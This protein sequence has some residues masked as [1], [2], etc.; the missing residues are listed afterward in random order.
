MSLSVRRSVILHPKC[1][2]GPLGEYCMVHIGRTTHAPLSECGTVALCQ[3]WRVSD[4]K[5]QK[6][7]RAGWNWHMVFQNNWG[8]GCCAFDAPRTRHRLRGNYSHPLDLPSSLPSAQ[9]DAVTAKI[10]V[11]WS[12]LDGKSVQI[13]LKIATGVSTPAPRLGSEGLGPT[14][15]GFYTWHSYQRPSPQ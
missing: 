6:Y 2:Q 7:Q 5:G 1:D 13:R 3:P 15:L 8:P 4:S 12:T 9:D 11:A 14:V 10:R